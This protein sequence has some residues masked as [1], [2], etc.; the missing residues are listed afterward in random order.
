MGG[1]TIREQAEHILF[2]LF[3]TAGIVV[4]E[5]PYLPARW[6]VGG[7]FIMNII[8]RPQALIEKFEH[9]VFS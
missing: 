6:I 1:G 8:M 2:D 3:L 7:I 9:L 4:S 5:A